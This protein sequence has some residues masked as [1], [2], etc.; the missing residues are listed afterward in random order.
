MDHA[1]VTLAN[2]SVR[3]KG[4]G[5]L[6]ASFRDVNRDKVL[7]LVLGIET[8][9]LELNETDVEAVLTG[10]TFDGTPIRGVDSVRVK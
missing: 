4:R 6:T 8:A 7:D 5:K 1:T 10:E 9:T 2:A 3:L